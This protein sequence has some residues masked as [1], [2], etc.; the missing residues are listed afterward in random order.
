VFQA[1]KRAP[2]RKR[3]G[4]VSLPETF[5]VLVGYDYFFDT[6]KPE[7]AGG[8]EAIEIPSPPKPQLPR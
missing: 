3:Q 2:V 7:L 8:P 5:K 4:L 1:E 6:K